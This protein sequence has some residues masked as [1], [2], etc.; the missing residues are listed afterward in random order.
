[1]SLSTSPAVAPVTPRTYSPVVTIAPVSKRESALGSEIKNVARF[2]GITLN[3]NFSLRGLLLI[4]A[5]AVVAIA[6]AN[7]AINQ[8]TDPTYDFAIAQFF[9]VFP[10]DAQ[11]GVDFVRNY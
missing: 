5:L 8:A 1:M 3:W 4:T 2:F 6:V 9:G 11:Y 10:S 7:I